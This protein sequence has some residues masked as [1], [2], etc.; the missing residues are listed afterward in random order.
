MTTQIL[1]ID[2]GGSSLKGAVVNV[3]TGELVSE[4]VKIEAPAG[5]TVQGVS[6]TIHQ[7]AKN[8]NYNG[9][10]GVGF[11]GIVIHGIVQSPPTALH[12]PGWVGVNVNEVF[13]QTCGMAVSVAND[14]DAA[15]LAE[16]VFGAGKDVKGVVITITLGTG[17]GS[18]MFMDGKL[19]PNFELGKLYLKGHNKVSELYMAS[20]IRE[21]KSLKWKAYGKRLN[22]YFQHVEWLFSPDLIIVGGG[23]SKD[24]EKFMPYIKLERSKIV[25]A[26]LF[27]EAGIVGAAALAM[28]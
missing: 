24:H 20:R 27:N 26:Q 7:I 18:G 3:A 21:E 28:S 25:P 19:V 9:P 14:A 1:G 16:V 2:V 6:D 8:L 12:Y 17:V 5:F 15:G 10:I 23:I 11:P 4:R 22:K 13:S